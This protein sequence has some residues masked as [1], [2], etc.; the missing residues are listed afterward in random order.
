M[1]TTPKI[2]VTG[3]TRNPDGR[4]TFNINGVRHWT[5]TQGWGLYAS[6]EQL[7]INPIT[8]YR[9]LRRVQV[10]LASGPE[11]QLAADPREASASVGIKLRELANTRKVSARREQQVGK[12][13]LVAAYMQDDA[14]YCNVYTQQVTVALSSPKS[15]AR[16]RVN[17]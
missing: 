8:G 6:K 9:R 16:E 1:K 3:F 4:Y 17:H 5:D 14:N 2:S 7:F 11:F 12:R 13:E 15:Q 10:C